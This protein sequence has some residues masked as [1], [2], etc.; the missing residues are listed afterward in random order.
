MPLGGGRVKC[1]DTCAI[2][3]LGFTKYTSTHADGT[4]IIRVL[5]T[6]DYYILTFKSFETT[7]SA[8][9]VFAW[10][11]SKNAPDEDEDDGRSYI[12]AVSE[13]ITDSSEKCSGR[14]KSNMGE[15]RMDIEDSEMAYLGYHDGE[16]YGLTW[17]VGADENISH[18]YMRRV[19]R[20]FA[21]GGRFGLRS[22]MGIQRGTS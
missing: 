17:K 22:M 19:D 21:V 16:S 7:R 20:Y 4:T 11:T 14:A 3:V 5:L 13:I 12:S 9:Q 18:T 2:P 1:K 15:A 10:D 8:P 6:A